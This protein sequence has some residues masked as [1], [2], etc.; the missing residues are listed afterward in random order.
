VDVINTIMQ[1]IVAPVA[2]FVWLLHV[3]TQSNTTDIAVIKA[4][5]AAT[6]E[7]SDREFKE[8]KDSF[9]AVLDKLDNIEQHLRT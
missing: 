8:V 2:A 1:W 6:K 4:T 7:A 9:K 3:K 5:T